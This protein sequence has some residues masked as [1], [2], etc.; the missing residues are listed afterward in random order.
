[1]RHDP[2]TPTYA[3]AQVICSGPGPFAVIYTPKPLHGARGSSE[4]AAKQST[5][6][7]IDCTDFSWSHARTEA[8]VHVACGAVCVLARSIDPSRARGRGASVVS[9]ARERLPIFSFRT[10]RCILAF[11]AFQRS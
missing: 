2:Y 7:P 4:A 6:P 1:M 8:V 3:R 5:P 9:P 10:R 11:R